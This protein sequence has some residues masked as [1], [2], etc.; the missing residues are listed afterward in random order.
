MNWTE[1][2]SFGTKVWNF[3]IKY[4]CRDN[5][6]KGQSVTVNQTN[7]FHGGSS[8]TNVTQS[9]NDVYYANKTDYLPEAQATALERVTDVGKKL[10]YELSER[11]P[12][13]IKEFKDPA[14]QDA[15]FKV[16]KHYALSGDRLLGDMLVDILVER[17]SNTNRDTTQIS[18]TEAIDVLPKLTSS[19]LKIVTL[20]YL[21]KTESFKVC[22][23][24][25]DVINYLEKILCPLAKEI[26][27]DANY[28]YEYNQLEYLR[29]FLWR[30]YNCTPIEYNILEACRSCFNREFTLEEIKTLVSRYSYHAKFDELFTTS[31][32]DTQKLQLKTSYGEVLSKIVKELEIP[33][34]EDRNLRNLFQNFEFMSNQQLEEHLT[35][36]LPN[37]HE[38]SNIASH[39]STRELTNVGIVIAQANYRRMNKK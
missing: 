24:Y 37:Y 5:A 29:C 39:L 32:F 10:S 23:S 33:K 16:Q 19:Q 8:S 31:I 34:E 27:A 15:L 35:S 9:F 22:Q 13:G 21:L 12:E 17:V 30:S 6:S 7:H 25:S 18:L 20:A 3:F 14:I 11:N 36:K 28:Y 26:T 38:L 1:I 4:I 2:L